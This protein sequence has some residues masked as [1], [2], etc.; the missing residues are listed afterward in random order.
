MPG[1]DAQPRPWPV[2]GSAVPSAGCSGKCTPHPWDWR[3]SDNSSQRSQLGVLETTSPA[4]LGNMRPR[5]WQGSPKAAGG[6]WPRRAKHLALPL[7]LSASLRQVPRPGAH[8]VS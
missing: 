1:S 8:P 2:L 7:A 3:Q 5:E 6:G 4:S